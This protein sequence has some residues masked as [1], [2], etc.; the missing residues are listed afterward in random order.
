MKFVLGIQVYTKGLR[1]P[2]DVGA[3]V[4]GLLDGVIQKVGTMVI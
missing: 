4:H 3:I 1:S 2:K